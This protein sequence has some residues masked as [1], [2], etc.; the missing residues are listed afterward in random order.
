MHFATKFGEIEKAISLC[1][2]KRWR[3]NK[4]KPNTITKT[5]A[6]SVFVLFLLSLGACN[7]KSLGV[8]I[9]EESGSVVVAK[10]NSKGGPPPHAPA[11]GYRAKYSY[12]YYPSCYVYFDISSKFYFYLAGD[13]WKVSEEEKEEGKMVIVGEIHIKECNTKAVRLRFFLQRSW[14]VKSMKHYLTLCGLFLTLM[15]TGCATALIG[16]GATG[17]YKVATDE[18][19]ADGMWDDSAITTKVKTG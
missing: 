2:F 15:A 7:I 13:G 3:T 14:R 10:S 12:R 9:G 1:H 18:R 5:L 16:A 8:Q 17:G 19:N 11:H 6:C 4:M